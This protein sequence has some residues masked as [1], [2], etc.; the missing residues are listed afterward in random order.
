MTENEIKVLRA[1]YE[2]RPP[3]RGKFVQ[4]CV[5][6]LRDKGYIKFYYDIG[7]LVVSD[8]GRRALKRISK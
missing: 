8:E 1:L 5:D 3:P 7:C 6:S 4:E 2:N